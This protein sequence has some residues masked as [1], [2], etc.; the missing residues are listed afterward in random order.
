MSSKRS[1]HRSE[2]D[3]AKYGN[4][5]HGSSQR[6]KKRERDKDE[7]YQPPSRTSRRSNNNPNQDEG[8]GEEEEEEEEEAAP[9]SRGKAPMQTRR[10]N[11]PPKRPS[12]R[13]EDEGSGE[14]EEEEEEEEAA[15]RSRGKVPMQTRRPNKPPKRPSSRPEDDDE[16][17]A[18][19]K[20]T[21][22]SN[23][24]KRS[25]ANVGNRMNVPE[26]VVEEDR[27]EDEVLTDDEDKDGGEIGDGE[28]DIA[29]EQ[30]EGIGDAAAQGAF[31]QCEQEKKKRQ[32]P[33]IV[34]YNGM[35]ATALKTWLEKKPAAKDSF[36]ATRGMFFLFCFCGI[37]GNFSTL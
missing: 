13:P 16:A 26:E 28:A 9:R 23:H 4:V 22:T 5:K 29:D 12:S 3:T 32:M 7:D 10:P 36:L 33:K 34:T 18:R 35:S 11:K 6:G 25:R 2:L 30:N 17:D 37:D 24:T 31:N 15:P 14:E 19:T 21:P 20:S 27:V 8:S 1:T